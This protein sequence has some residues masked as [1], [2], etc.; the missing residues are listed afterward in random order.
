MYNPSTPNNVCP[1]NY[2]K[3]IFA[4]PFPRINLQ[5]TTTKEI[6]EIVKSLKSTNSHGY[7][8]IPTKVLKLSLPFIISPLIYICNKSL[9]KGIFP[10][11]L[12]F[13]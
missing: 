5:P 4:R 8:E 10:T 9:L 6:T 13:S 3:Q 7:N 11:Q 12:K 2:L 1:L